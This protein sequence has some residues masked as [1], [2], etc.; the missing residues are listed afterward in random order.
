MQGGQ[1][2]VMALEIGL[3]LLQRLEVQDGHQ[4]L[5]GAKPQQ[6]HAKNRMVQAA[7]GVGD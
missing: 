5:T 3:S 6:I 4:L 7:V 2:L 1:F